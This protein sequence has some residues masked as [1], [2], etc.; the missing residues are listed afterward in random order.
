M[1]TSDKEENA[2]KH[3]KLLTIIRDYQDFMEEHGLTEAMYQAW[4][5]R[6]RNIRYH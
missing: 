6:K 4:Q 2:K 5:A 3:L 1:T